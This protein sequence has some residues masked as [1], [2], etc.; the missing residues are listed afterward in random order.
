MRDN[1]QT[2]TRNLAES[3]VR[4]EDDV[5]ILAPNADRVEEVKAVLD[6]IAAHLGLD[7]SYLLGASPVEILD[8]YEETKV[9]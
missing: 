4:R 9:S 3:I 8:L 7:K 6:E 5:H 1:P 2:T